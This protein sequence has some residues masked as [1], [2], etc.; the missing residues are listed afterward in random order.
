MALGKASRGA[1]GL[2][3]VSGLGLAASV[4]YY[5]LPEDGIDGS[6][7]VAIVIAST[8]LM[9]IASAAIAVGLTRGW[10]KRV[11]AALILLDVIGTGFAAYMLE[12]SVLI[13]LMALA[14]IV[15]LYAVLAGDRTTHLAS[16][17]AAS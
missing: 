6:L 1:V 12:A 15:W 3:A 5:F 11:L 10:V 16:V 7:G 9:L 14:L 4:A 17:E 8:A 13:A 2:V